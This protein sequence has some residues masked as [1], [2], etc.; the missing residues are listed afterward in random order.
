MTTRKPPPPG[1]ASASNVLPFTPPPSVTPP[2][3]WQLNG[4]FG[5][6]RAKGERG[7]P[8]DLARLGDVLTWYESTHEL[9]RAAALVALID[10][11][12]VALERGCYL[13]CPSGFAERLPP[14]FLY[15]PEHYLRRNQRSVRSH[16]LDAPEAQPTPLFAEPR[17]EPGPHCLVRCI[18]ARWTRAKSTTSPH[19]STTENP[20]GGANLLAVPMDMAHQAWGYGR[21]E[22]QA[23]DA[24]AVTLTMPTKWADLV[25]YHQE[26]PGHDWS[27][28]LK[29]IIAQEEGKRK[30]QKGIRTGLAAALGMTLTRLSE[31]IRTKDEF[32]KKQRKEASRRTGTK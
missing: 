6:M 29:N 1:A 22:R 14:D 23:V 21:V 17:P 12:P 3:G 2:D 18:T 28:E 11:L 32:G 27:V 5:F 19:R 16:G 25:V 26:N 15:W 8:F 7:Q 30:G 9:P 31:L 13:L 20:A 10:G 4:P 24:L